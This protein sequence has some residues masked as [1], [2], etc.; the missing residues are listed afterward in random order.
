VQAAAAAVERTMTA[1]KAGRPLDEIG[2]DVMTLDR[3]NAL[4]GL[5]EHNAREERFETAGQ[6][7]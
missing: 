7:G 1:L 3:Y 4:V 2:A 5:A 6:R